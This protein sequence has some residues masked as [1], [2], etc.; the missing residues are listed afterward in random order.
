M[1]DIY[2]SIKV[3]KSEFQ[4]MIYTEKQTHMRSLKISEETDY[5]LET[6]KLLTLKK[7]K[8]RLS[9][10]GVVRYALR[11]LAE[12]LEIMVEAKKDG[13]E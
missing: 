8:L 11:A 13:E 7:Y 12:K 6:I 1:E 2:T 10:G 3:V 4:K 9:K 5:Q